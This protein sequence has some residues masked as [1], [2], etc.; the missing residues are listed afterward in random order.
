MYMRMVRA[1][2]RAGQQEALCSHYETEIIPRLGGVPGCTFAGLLN[3]T[4]NPEEAISMTLWKTQELS[5]VYAK[6]ALFPSML[7]SIHPFLVE[8]ME[9]RLQLS[10]DLTLEFIPVEEKPVIESY[11]VEVEGGAESLDQAT[12]SAPCVRIV[13]LKIA[14]GK[15]EEFKKI[16][17]KSVVST[18]RTVKGCRHVF[19]SQSAGN[20]NEFISTTVWNSVEEADAYD[21]G[22]LFKMLMEWMKH[23]LPEVY[24]WKME[25]QAAGKTGV[26]TSE[27]L[28]VENY[29]VMIARGFAG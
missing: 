18:L 25:Q 29:A 14:Q 11:S 19:L 23:T 10:E 24:Q 2:V 26:V 15:A 21:H 6:S 22:E 5:E 12:E 13:L 20:P 4:R 7:A 16:Y 3:N 9:S 1:K 8:S 27:E 17:G 28:V